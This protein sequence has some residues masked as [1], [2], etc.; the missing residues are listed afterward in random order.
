[1]LDKTLKR[2]C[3]IG[4]GRR[5]AASYSWKSYKVPVR[6]AQHIQNCAVTLSL[7][8]RRDSQARPYRS[9]FLDGRPPQ[10]LDHGSMVCLAIEL[11]RFELCGCSS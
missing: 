8:A 7:K 9:E 2:L 10:P 6:C 3:R 11:C 5:A 1:M 4:Y